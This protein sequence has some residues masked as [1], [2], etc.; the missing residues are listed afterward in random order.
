MS[1]TSP[2]PRVAWSERLVRVLSKPAVSFALAFASIALVWAEP[3][4]SGNEHDYLAMLKSF[5]DPAF[6]AGDWSFSPT[7]PDRY[8]FDLVF[9][10]L[11]AFVPVEVLGWAGRLACWALALVALFRIGGRLGLSRAMATLAIAGWVLVGQSLVGR[12]WMVGTFEAKAVAWVLFLF[13]LDGAFQARWGRTAVLAGLA[14]TM[15]PAAGGIAAAAL[16]GAALA[17]HRPRRDLLKPALLGLVAALPGLAQAWYMVAFSDP[18]SSD[19]WAFLSSTLLEAVLDLPNFPRLDLALSVVT[20]ALALAWTWRRRAE[21]AFALLFWLNVLLL[22]VFLVG[23]AAH[24]TGEYLLL[25]ITPF[26]H[27]PVVSLLT[28]FLVASSAQA[29]RGPARRGPLDSFLRVTLVVLVVESAV[30]GAV[31]FTAG[32][33]NLPGDFPGGVPGT[34]FAIGIVVAIATA[35]RP[36]L[37]RSLAGRALA[38][39]MLL[40]LASAAPVVGGSFGRYPSVIDRGLRLQRSWTRQ[41]DDWDRM[42]E[43]LATGTAPGTVILVPPWRSDATMKAGRPQVA[44]WSMPRYDHLASWRRR[45]EPLVGEL[46]TGR[47]ATTEARTAALRDHYLWMRSETITSL[48]AEYGASVYITDSARLYPVIHEEG[49]VRAYFIGKLGDKP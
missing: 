39:A 28:F 29:G 15:H 4:P 14:I 41:P 16:G 19:D 12:E 5:W 24:L 48:V 33:R 34:A 26:R 25:S 30:A 46:P 2:D 27:L 11:A 49:S 22:P 9:G 3:V 8:A 6:L 44:Y 7:L 36:L 17:V 23:V 32:E 18:A 45:V 31:S 42:F 20:L 43:W 40:L 13:A 35:R 21:R 47:G 10:T 38:T 1:D 37:D